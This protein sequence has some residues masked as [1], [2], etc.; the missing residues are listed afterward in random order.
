ML[1]NRK[2]AV[3]ITRLYSFLMCFNVDAHPDGF[4][5][6]NDGVGM[7]LPSQCQCRFRRVAGTN[8]QTQK[9]YSLLRSM[10]ESSASVNNILVC[11]QIN[12]K[13]TWGTHTHTSSLLDVYSLPVYSHTVALVFL[14][15][16]QEHYPH[17]C[18]F[19][20]DPLPVPLVSRRRQK[21]K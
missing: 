1:S 12:I 8:T 6:A 19:E 16:R 14:A 17:G 4:I 5:G 7:D 3:G 9:P 11:G 10:K 13:D 21:R 15:T 2:A 20:T 18:V